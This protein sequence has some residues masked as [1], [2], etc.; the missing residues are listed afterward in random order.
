[1]AI[2]LFKYINSGSDLDKVKN[3]SN[4]P[5]EKSKSSGSEPETREVYPSREQVYAS[6]DHSGEDRSE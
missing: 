1:M 2:F 6:P 5:E 4:N 3:Y